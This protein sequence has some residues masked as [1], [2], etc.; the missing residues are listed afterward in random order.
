MSSGLYSGVSGLAI[1]SGLYKDV[2]SLW[3]GASGLVT[4]WGGGGYSPQAEAYFAAMTV[5]PDAARKALLNT[6]INT[7]VAG[8]VW[9]KLDWLAIHAAHDNQ[10][11]RINAVT[12]SE[13]ATAVN[14]PTFTTDR[15]FTGDGATSYLN[16][17]VTL[18]GA[19]YTLNDAH[20]GVWVGT[21]VSSSAQL[22]VGLYNRLA[23]CSRSTTTLRYFSNRTGANLPTLPVA[24]SV[25]HSM[26]SRSVNTESVP[27]KN[28]V[29]LGAQAGNTTSI[30]GQELYI[31]AVNATDGTDAPTFFST[32]RIQA[33]HWGSNLTSGEVTTLYNALSTYMTA[34][35]A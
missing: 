7:L 23:I 15:G 31:C 29:S 27:Y 6:L 16:S 4:D 2:S 17:N 13:V 5:Q 3:S 10:A 34:I 20:L 21:D 28:G 9:A 35:G 25:G 8:G 1:G 30:V 14:S 22:D 24:T 12:P 26:W 11:G 33:T 18:S 32:R 19:L